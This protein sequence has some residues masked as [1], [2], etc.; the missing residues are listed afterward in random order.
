MK[1]SK[2][3]ACRWVAPAILAV[4]ALALLLVNLG[5]DLG[6]FGDWVMKWWPAGVLL[7][8]VS[9]FCPCGSGGCCGSCKK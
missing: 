2:C 7:Y 9:G 3:P 6:S 5:V 4:T 1:E 8:A